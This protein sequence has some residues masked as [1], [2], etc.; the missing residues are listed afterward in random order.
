MA[1]LPVVD[2]P[3]VDSVRKSLFEISDG[4][5]ANSDLDELPFVDE[6]FEIVS[7]SLGED[8]SAHGGLKS[9]AF[10]GLSPKTLRI[11]LDLVAGLVDIPAEERLVIAV[12]RA[13]KP[14]GVLIMISSL[15]YFY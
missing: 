8:L 10:S 9:I 4:G 12:V 5:T 14:S 3:S 6:D 7:S 1:G 11:K 2:G 13:S 15:S